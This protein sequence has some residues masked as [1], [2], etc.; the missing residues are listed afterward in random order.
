MILTIVQHTPLRVW[1]IL[2]G[3]VA[4]G[5]AQTRTR[6]LSLARVTVLPLVLLALSL[7]G[8]MASFGVLPVALAAWAAGLSMALALPRRALA[9][10]G[11]SWSAAAQSLHV[12]GSWLPLLLMVGTFVIKYV[13][14]ASLAVQPALASNALFAGLCSLGFGTFSGL[15]LA[16][17]LDL[18]RLATGRLTLATPM[19]GGSMVAQS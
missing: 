8:V 15:F 18:R 12:P 7:A 16:R 9:K 5:L 6:E 11:A 2:A 1:F 13:A 3:L 14:G 10:P 4:L 19:P 17:S